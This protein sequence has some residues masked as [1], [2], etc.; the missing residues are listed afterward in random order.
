MKIFLH[1]YPLDASLEYS[2]G[3]IYNECYFDIQHPIFNGPN[4]SM[5]DLNLMIM[6]LVYT[7]AFFIDAILSED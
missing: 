2:V 7:M 6:L 1:S 3:A 5:I 4:T